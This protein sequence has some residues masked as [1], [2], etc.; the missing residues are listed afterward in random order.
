MKIDSVYL[1]LDVESTQCMQWVRLVP[2]L[3]SE[4]II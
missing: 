4:N 1:V 2:K 3:R